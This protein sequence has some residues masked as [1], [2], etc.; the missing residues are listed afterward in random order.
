M[1]AAADNS[2]LGAVT[3]LPARQTA[4]IVFCGLNPVESDKITRRII[5]FTGHIIDW[6]HMTSLKILLNLSFFLL[7]RAIS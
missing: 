4:K 2:H 3:R 7:L 5:I 6:G 1:P